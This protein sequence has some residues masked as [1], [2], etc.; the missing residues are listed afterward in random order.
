M[1]RAYRLYWLFVLGITTK[2]RGSDAEG[3]KCTIVSGDSHG[4]I[5]SEARRLEHSDYESGIWTQA[6]DSDDDG[7]L[8]LVVEGGP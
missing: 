1:N 8:V 3:G 5:R 4:H 7:S 2:S 6:P